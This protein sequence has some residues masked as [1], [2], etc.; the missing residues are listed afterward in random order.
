MVAKL[1][2]ALDM[3]GRIT[4][5]SLS[6]SPTFA[7]ATERNFT[8]CVL[9][10]PPGQCTEVLELLL[11]YLCQK[12]TDLEAGVQLDS[13][14]PPL[15]RAS[16]ILGLVVSHLPAGLWSSKQGEKA[17]Q[18]LQRLIR[19]ILLPLLSACVEQVNRCQY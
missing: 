9:K 18:L 4:T 5:T 19:E 15:E 17:V 2:E 12:I 13:F 1:L 7:P 3:L 16:D 11:T 14:L 8:E 10:L 6:T